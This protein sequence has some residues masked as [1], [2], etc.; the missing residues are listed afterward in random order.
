MDSLAGLATVKFTNKEI[1]S[2]SKSPFTI[3]TACVD[4]IYIDDSM[5]C[6]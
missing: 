6:E 5:T 2:S 1:S 4:N 3:V